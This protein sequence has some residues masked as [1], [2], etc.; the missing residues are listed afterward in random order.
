MFPDRPLQ[1]SISENPQKLFDALLRCVEMLNN[2]K[3]VMEVECVR[4]GKTR[5]VLDF[6]VGHPGLSVRG[7]KIPPGC[8]CI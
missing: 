5:V 8:H 7:D 1:D 6:S 2:R 3:F 4:N